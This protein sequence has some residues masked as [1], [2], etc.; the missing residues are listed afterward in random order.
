ME[1][2]G[3]GLGRGGAC[4]NASVP[5]VSCSGTASAQAPIAC[6]LPQLCKD[7]TGLLVDPDAPQ[8]QAWYTPRVTLAGLPA[9][10]AAAG[11]PSAAQL[12]G[13]LKCGGCSPVS[14]AD[15]EDDAVALLST[16]RWGVWALVFLLPMCPWARV[17]ACRLG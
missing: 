9:G 14:A 11:W 17:P 7:R 4:S 12:L 1:E 8:P 2:G 16:G 6:P 3:A 5:S 13:L 10:A 15:I